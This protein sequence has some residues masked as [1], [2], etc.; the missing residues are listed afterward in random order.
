MWLISAEFSSIYRVVDN[1]LQWTADVKSER[2]SVCVSGCMY[3]CACE[4]V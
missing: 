1:G 4:C 3:I 2:E